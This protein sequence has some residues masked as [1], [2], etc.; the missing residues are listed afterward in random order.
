MA[1]SIEQQRE[2]ARRILQGT[3]LGRKQQATQGLWPESEPEESKSF[4]K[5][6]V[7]G[8]TSPFRRAGVQAYN[9]GSGIIKGL[10]GDIEGAHAEL[11]KTR[12]LGYLGETAPTLKDSTNFA[13][14]TNNNDDLGGAMRQL[15]DVAG[16]GLEAGSFFTG[17]GALKNVAQTGFK[18]LVKE[19][20]KQ[21]FKQGVASGLTGGFGMG[22]QDENATVG[23]VAGSTALGG[24]FGGVGGAA[25]GGLS[26][27][28][29]AGFNKLAGKLSGNFSKQADDIISVG[30][31]KGVRPSVAGK[32][33]P[34]LYSKFMDRSKLAVKYIAENADE[35]NLTD[36][37]GA[38]IKLPR[39]LEEFSTAISKSKQ[40]VFGK[41]DFL[42]RQA[43]EGDA[44]VYLGGISSQLRKAADNTALRLKHPEY[45]K[46]LMDTAQRFDEQGSLGSVE[47][48]ELIQM[49][50][51]ELKAFY[52]NP[53]P[54]M[55]NKMTI[56]AMIVNNM[57]KELD[58]TIQSAS[59]QNY[60]ALKST[61]GAL[62][63]LE[64]EV[65]H[66]TVIANRANVR[67]L[68]DLTDVFSGS[69]VV[70]GILTAN[71]VQVAGGLTQKVI[72]NAF[73]KMN[74]PNR[75]VRDM[76]KNVGKLVEKA[77][78][79]GIKMTPA[80]PMRTMKALPM[81]TGPRG[82]Q[83]SVN[84][85]TIELPSR[86][87]STI[88]ASEIAGARATRVVRP[89][90]TS[91]KREVTQ[92]FGG[93]GNVDVKPKLASLKGLKGEVLRI[94]KEVNDELNKSVPGLTTTNPKAAELG[95]KLNEL[96]KQWVNKPTP[97]NKKALSLV[98]RAYQ[99]AIKAGGTA[100]I[101][102]GISKN[103]D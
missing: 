88:D 102:Y 103:A 71:P 53:T 65:A 98:R 84:L 20:A 74:D 59:G 77:N 4:L 81:G 54:Q 89:Q 25:F 101:A 34:E 36:D 40:N 51:T 10:K 83:P 3:S 66:R 73:K 38:K 58:E 24:V 62:A 86:S 82:K 21:G 94:A 50:N 76:F 48:D 87:Q 2:R 68:A 44:R 1:E 92:I 39:N 96:N 64:K 41:Y 55:A 7:Q 13:F 60:Q 12:N 63:E 19:S 85:D 69:Q 67:G 43:G 23:S 97:A 11:D 37:T 29:G 22:L 56:D 26:G 52:R 61:Y 75:I 49:F 31:E 6:M 78:K 100:A 46:Y 14:D 80:A 33:T 9:T 95:V 70:Q 30:I 35:L 32:K 91:A 47:A 17:G 93:E 45:V 90:G 72:A 42:R 57:R 99:A 79:K 5:S 18:G 28:A 15:G 8:I 27:A 16:Q